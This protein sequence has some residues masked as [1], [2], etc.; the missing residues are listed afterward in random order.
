MQMQP[1]VNTPLPSGEQSVIAIE[2]VAQHIASNVNPETTLG[3]CGVC[4]EWYEVVTGTGDRC[5]LCGYL[6]GD[7]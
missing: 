4:R 2:M 7:L 3:Y 1:V 6:A 5:P